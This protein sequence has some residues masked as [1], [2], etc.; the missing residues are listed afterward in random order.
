MRQ[1]AIQ[2]QKSYHRRPGESV[3]DYTNISFDDELAIFGGRTRLVAPKRS[4]ERLP[5]TT[6]SVVRPAAAESGLARDHSSGRSQSYVHNRGHTQRHSH[7]PLAEVT[8][9]ADLSIGWE[10]LYREI[11]EPSY[12]SG[13]GDSGAMHT[14]NSLGEGFMLDD[15]WSSFMHHYGILSDQ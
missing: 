3:V 7:A 5:T 6:P 2:A 12:G 11:P 13:T 1:K 8:H 14:A 10:G 15:R 9:P 4:F